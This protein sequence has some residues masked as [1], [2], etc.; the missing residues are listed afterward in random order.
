YLRVDGYNEHGAG[1]SDIHVQSQKVKSLRS[2]L[3]FRMNYYLRKCNFTFIPEIY[4]EW[5][6]EYRNKHRNV[7]IE[8]IASVFPGATLLVPGTGR[9]IAL[10]GVDLLFTMHD[11]VGIEVSY[12]T[13]YNSLYHDHF[14][15]LGVDFRF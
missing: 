5:Q 6:R 10:A 9:N 3:G 11:R 14:F 12:E 1:S 2:S 13:E 15:Y 8:G 4:G 7:G